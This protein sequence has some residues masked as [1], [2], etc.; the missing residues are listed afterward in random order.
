MP[1][2]TPTQ[3]AAMLD[4]AQTGDYAYPAINVTSLPTLNGALKAFAESE[5]RRH[6]PGQH[7]RRRI[8]LRHRGQG[9]GA[10]RHRARGSGPHVWPE[11]YNVLIA[12]HTDHCQPKKVDTFLK[13]LI[14][15]TAKRRAAGLGNLFN[16]HMLD[17]SRTAARRR[18]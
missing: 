13:P 16:S 15:E 8:R 3:F 14:A 17:A 9:H 7:R 6:H 11:R 4:A 10:R 18:T 1:I 12:L 5:I 2:A